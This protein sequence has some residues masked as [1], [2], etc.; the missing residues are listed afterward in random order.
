MFE[1]IKWHQQPI[2]DARVQNLDRML[3]SIQRCMILAPFAQGNSEHAI[4]TLCD[5]KFINGLHKFT[6]A[7]LV[8]DN[9]TALGTSKLAEENRGEAQNGS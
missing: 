1:G 7:E 4:P 5:T 3:K 9:Q 2:M 6:L 8:W